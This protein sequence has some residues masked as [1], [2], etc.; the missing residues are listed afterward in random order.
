MA[1]QQQKQLKKY[2]GFTSRIDDELKPFILKELAERIL[3]EQESVSINKVVS[4]LVRSSLKGKY[5][6]LAH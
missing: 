2:S 4:D 6:E 5:P 1:T 3:K